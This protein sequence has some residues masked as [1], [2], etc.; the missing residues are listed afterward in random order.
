MEKKTGV[1]RRTPVGCWYGI[2]CQKQRPGDGSAEQGCVGDDVRSHTV[3]RAVPFALVSLTT[4]FEMGPGRPSPLL[5]PTHPC[6]ALPPHQ[7]LPL[8]VNNSSLALLPSFGTR[9][10]SLL[11]AFAS[12]PH[13]TK[14]STLSTGW[15][16]TLLP[17]HLPPI[18]LVVFERSYSL[19]GWGVSS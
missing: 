17:F 8:V 4:G 7:R 14:S 15:L 3:T 6:L 13:Q 12:P 16:Q 10:R 11:K 19:S 1:L 18:Q 9:L 2:C 5:S